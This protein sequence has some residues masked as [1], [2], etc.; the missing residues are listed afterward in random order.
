[1]LANHLTSFA[2]NLKR[3]GETKPDRKPKTK[4]GKFPCVLM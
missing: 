3:N 2:D 4:E 1:M